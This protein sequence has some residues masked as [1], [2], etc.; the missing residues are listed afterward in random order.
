[1]ITVQK[2]DVK[3][4]T[5]FTIERKDGPRSIPFQLTLPDGRVYTLK[6]YFLEDGYHPISS[7]LG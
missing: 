7:R 1:M 5:S 4:G 3:W 6:E 2:T